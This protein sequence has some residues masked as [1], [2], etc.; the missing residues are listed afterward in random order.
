MFCSL[1]ERERR[2]LHYKKN[3]LKLAR[4]H[5]AAG[6]IEKVDRYYV[7]RDDVVSISGQVLH[8]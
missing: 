4:E 5:R 8:T 2:D 6:A 3:V 7:P 1:T